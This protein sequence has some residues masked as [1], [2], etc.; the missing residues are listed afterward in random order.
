MDLICITPARRPL[1]QH[2]ARARPAADRQGTVLYRTSAARGWDVQHVRYAA[3]ILAA[4]VS[5]S[6]AIQQVQRLRRSRCRGPAVRL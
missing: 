3:L 5:T 4:R 1:L 2:G 6:K